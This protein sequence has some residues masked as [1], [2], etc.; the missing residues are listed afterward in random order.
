MPFFSV[1]IPLYNKEEYIEET[2][3]SVLNQ[4]FKDFEVII[5]NDGSTDNSL[6]IVKGFNDERI[7]IHNQKNKGA[8]HTRNQCIKKSRGKY[9]ALLDADDFWESNHLQ[10]LKKLIDKFPNA[11]LYCNNYS[12]RRS[13]NLVFPTLFNFEHPNDCLIIPD[14]FASNIIDCIPSSSSTA[15][16]KSC[17]NEIGGY[18]TSIRSGQDTDLWIKFGLKYKVAFNPIVTMTYN[19]YDLNSLSNSKYNNDRYKF[20]NTYA[21]EEKENKSLKKYLDI[22]RYALAIRCLLNDEYELCQKLKKEIYY[23]NL[24]LK[25]RILLSFPKYILKKANQFQKFLIK[26]NIYLTA[27]N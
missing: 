26:N 19:N 13:K 12:I 23:K 8:A 11:G 4:T 17:F 27:Y 25:Q 3:K 24:T 16:L 14:F 15:F 18:N 9:M 6:T 21:N 10:E 22:N 1:V 2:L 20:I 7:K 5:V